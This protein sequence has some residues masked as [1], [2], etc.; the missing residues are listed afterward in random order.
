M[1]TRNFLSKDAATAI[2]GRKPSK[3]GDNMAKAR[4]AAFAAYKTLGGDFGRGSKSSAELFLR[5][6]KDSAG[7]LIDESDSVHIYEC[8]AGSAVEAAGGIARLSLN[9]KASSLRQGITAAK[10]KDVNFVKTLEQ[11]TDA[12]RKAVAGKR[13]VRSLWE[14]YVAVAR[15]QLKQ[16]DKAISEKDIAEAM[17]P[18]QSTK[19]AASKTARVV[20]A[21]QKM[22]PDEAREVLK[23]LQDKASGKKP[24]VKAMAAKVT[25]DQLRDMLKSA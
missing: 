22:T 15:L 9:A 6:C 25:I 3:G 11:A 20:A 23:A 21:V 8:Y 14:T 2:T 12:Y 10:L 24:K 17:K 5:V 19:E 4:E 18:F 16:T 13:K 1:V 7:G